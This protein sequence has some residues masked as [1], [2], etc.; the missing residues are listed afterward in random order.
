MSEK[1]IG[2]LRK[3]CARDAEKEEEEEKKK[4]QSR[5]VRPCAA[6]LSPC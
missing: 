4:K 5:D 3:N 6:L 1:C 2:F